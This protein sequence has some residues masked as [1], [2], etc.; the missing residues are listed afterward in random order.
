[1]RVKHLSDIPLEPT[2]LGGQARV[3]LEHEHARVVNLV[4]QPGEKVAAHTGPVEV[5]FLVLQGAG[6]LK[7]EDESFPLAEGSLLIC[8]AGVPRS[9]ESSPNEVLSLL[10]VR[11][12][13]PG[14]YLHDSG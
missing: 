4:L 2:P 6:I 8:P 10:V 9:L 7:V 13:N 1:M 12:P 14:Q 11:S 3:L 5:L